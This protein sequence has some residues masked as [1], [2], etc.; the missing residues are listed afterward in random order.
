MTKRRA[1]SAGKRRG[2]D[3]RAHSASKDARERAGDT[4]PKGGSSA[5]AT[6]AS[7]ASGQRG[8]FSNVRAPATRP[9][10]GSSARAKP[11]R[12]DPLDRL[13]DAAARALA[14]PLD[15]AWK[16]MV[17]ANLEVT[18]RLAGLFADFPLPDDAEPAPVFKA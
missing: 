3:V 2:K 16:P 18:L 9:K 6:L 17:K 12:H 13:V 1:K 11:A 5:R 10:G 8:R 15:P 4:R 14:L 7:E